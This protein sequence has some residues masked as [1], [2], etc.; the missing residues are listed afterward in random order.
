M[1]APDPHA[2]GS[3]ELPLC[4]ILDLTMLRDGRAIVEG[5]TLNVAPRTVHVVVGPNGGGKSSVLEALLGEAPFSGTARFHFR[6]SGRIGY[7]PQTFLADATL[8]I[9]VA[10]FLALSRQLL[11]V[12]LGVRSATRAR[13]AAL[14]ERVGLVGVAGRRLGALSGGELKRVLLAHAL[15]PAPEL[16]VLDEPSTGLDAASAARLES[17][18]REERSVRGTTVLMVSHDRAQVRRLADAVTWIDRIVLREG[19]PKAVFATADELT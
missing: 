13:I 18:V 7:V 17:I 3:A 11:P 10:E 15:D 1:T 2:L 12:C 19:P 5:V 9:T 8:P 4:E 6:G 16:L 14:L